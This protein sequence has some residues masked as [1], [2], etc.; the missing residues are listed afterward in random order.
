MK[1]EEN[2]MNL[3]SVCLNEEQNFLNHFNSSGEEKNY[4][5][6]RTSYAGRARYGKTRPRVIQRVLP[7]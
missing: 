2:F 5:V 1:L 7:L 6:H 4:M 3:R